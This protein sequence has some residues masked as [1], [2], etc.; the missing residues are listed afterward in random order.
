MRQNFEIGN[1]RSDVHR[2]CFT[3]VRLFVVEF[4]SGEDASDDVVVVARRTVDLSIQR[5]LLAQITSND[6]DL[7]WRR[8][9]FARKCLSKSSERSGNES[10]HDPMRH[11]QI[12]RS[13]SKTDQDALI[14]KTSP[15]FFLSLSQED[16][17]MEID[18]LHRIAN[19]YQNSPDLRLTWLQNMAQ[20][21]LSVMRNISCVFALKSERTMRRKSVH[22]Q[23]R[24][25]L[26]RVV[27]QLMRCN[28]HI[29]RN[30]NKDL[31]ICLKVTVV[32][33]YGD[34]RFIVDI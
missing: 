30:T 22:Q 8:Y 27:F 6:L 24:V 9:R 17:D 14:A 26:C 3:F 13:Q 21:H 15:S 5:D 4:L 31:S 1:V 12:T 33:C 34:L 32:N 16:P 10:L 11:G 7:R 20:K 2:C 29:F 18:L 25:N 23:R 19:C 28:E